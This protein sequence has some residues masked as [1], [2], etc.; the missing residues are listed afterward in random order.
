MSSA[1]VPHVIGVFC[2]SRL[3]RP[4]SSLSSG[5]V[6][7]IVKRM[8]RLGTRLS[9]MSFPL[10]PDKVVRHVVLVVTPLS[11]TNSR[12]LIS[13]VTSEMRFACADRDDRLESDDVA[14]LVSF[15]QAGF[16]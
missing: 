8:V 5:M 1:D 16:Y 15:D 12:D 13:R 11:I 10:A 9:V 7:C 2:T 6:G 3:V 4:S 14:K